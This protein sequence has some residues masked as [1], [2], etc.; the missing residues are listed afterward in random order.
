M[1]E[2]IQ[3][4]CGWDHTIILLNNH[5]CYGFGSNLWGQIGLGTNEIKE[6][7]TPTLIKIEDKVS[8]LFLFLNLNIYFFDN[9]FK[10]R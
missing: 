2:V 4:Y 6:T 3:I 10:T 7:Q 9:F 5:Q 8:L 1:I